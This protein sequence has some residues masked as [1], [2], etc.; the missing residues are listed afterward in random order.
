MRGAKSPEDMREGN[1]LDGR[2]GQNE[3]ENGLCK[4]G[5]NPIVDAGDS[6]RR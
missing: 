3:Y 1:F 5:G 2:T 4:E 6:T